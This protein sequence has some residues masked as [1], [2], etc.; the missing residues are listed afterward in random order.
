MTLH[1]L[2]SSLYNI[3][4]NKYVSTENDYFQQKMIIFNRKWLFSIEKGL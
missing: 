3:N 2:P 4:M 1:T